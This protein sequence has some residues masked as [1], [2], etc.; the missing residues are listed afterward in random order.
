MCRG[1]VLQPGEYGE[2]GRRCGCDTSEARRLR[3]KAAKTVE[4]YKSRIGFTVDTENSPQ[5]PTTITPYQVLT[6]EEAQREAEV[7]KA[8]YQAPVPYGYTQEQWDAELELRSTAVGYAIAEEAER[9]ANINYE[10]HHQTLQAYDEA[11]IPLAQE[12]NANAD[13]QE[14]LTLNREAE[15]LKTWISNL[16]D[17][18]EIT[19]IR[20][21]TEI[22]NGILKAQ[23][24]VGER[25]GGE[26]TLKKAT[27]LEELQT[28]RKDTVTRAA[29]VLGESYRETLEQF[30]TFGGEVEAEYDEP[31]IADFMEEEVSPFYPE[32]WLQKSGQAGRL[33]IVEAGLTTR[34]NYVAAGSLNVAHVAAVPGQSEL[35]NR[36]QESPGV[37]PIKENIELGEDLKNITDGKPITGYKITHR[38]SFNPATDKLGDN[39]E[40][41]P[42]S[43]GKQ[44]HYGYP[45]TGSGGTK[46]TLTSNKQWYYLKTNEGDAVLTISGTA[47]TLV[48]ETNSP[49]KNAVAIHELGHRMEATIPN[50]ALLRA[51]EAFLR[52]RT[53][54]TTTG[55]PE[56]ISYMTY[57]GRAPSKVMLDNEIGYK[58]NFIHHYVGKQYLTEDAYEVFT[59]GVESLFGHSNGGLAGLHNPNI[60]DAD[61]RAFTLGVLASI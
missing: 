31:I 8:L 51:E 46:E 10:K 58:D 32:E 25:M 38:V 24:V 1:K 18:Y 20:E 19:A 57:T 50:R 14:W 39:G 60:K 34:P 30:R 59:V 61:H 4:A 28:A 27:Q 49:Y 35:V 33:Q 23:E 41:L 47:E 40:P 3:R 37:T 56:K 15:E 12:L 43:D 45:F 55:E 13:Y 17:R 26:E 48:P 36:L 9:Q 2:P 11:I 22:L 52:R 7:L 21:N 53:T 6:L 29:V 42:R 5:K 44:W 16:D 54:N